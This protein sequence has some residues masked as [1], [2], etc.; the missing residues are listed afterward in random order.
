MDACK[1]LTMMLHP[2]LSSL[3]SVRGLLM[4]AVLQLIKHQ[5]GNIAIKLS[6]CL[7]GNPISVATVGLG[8]AHEVGA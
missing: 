1:T 4:W 2:V 8:L 6:M 7:S 3:W 5:P